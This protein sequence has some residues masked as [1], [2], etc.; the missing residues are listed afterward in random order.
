M[1]AIE[2]AKEYSLRNK[3]Q[4]KYKYCVIKGNNSAAVHR[5]MELRSDR[6]EQTN[7]FDKLFNFKWQ[8]V[9]RGIQ[10]D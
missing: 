10:F 7:H 1:L 5:C 4:T 3:M 9:S 8:P 6:W 2:Q